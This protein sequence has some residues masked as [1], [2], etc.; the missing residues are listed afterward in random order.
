M[1]ARLSNETRQ[2][3]CQR[4]NDD[5]LIATSIRCSCKLCTTLARYLRAQDKVR[6]EWPLAKRGRAHIHGILD[7][8]DL[9][10]THIT[11]RTGRPFTLILEKTAA[12]FERDAP[13]PSAGRAL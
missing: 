11:R 5:W 7:S 2:T 4:P 6:F 8:H 12:V 3:R 13:L 10:V 1:A 9:P